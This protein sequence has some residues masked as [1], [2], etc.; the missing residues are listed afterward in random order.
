MK[1]T[2]SILL[3]LTLSAAASVPS[4]GQSNGNV[5]THGEDYWLNGHN[6]VAYFDNIT[7]TPIY[8]SDVHQ[9][10]ISA[11]PADEFTTPAAAVAAFE[12]LLAE[13][14]NLFRFDPS[15]LD[16]IMARPVNLSTGLS[17]A[18]SASQL[19]QGLEV[20]GG[21][22]GAMIQQDGSFISLWALVF[23]D[24]AID[25]MPKLSA[26]EADEFVRRAIADSASGV[27]GFMEFWE[28]ATVDTARLVVVVEVE[29]EKY[30][31]YLAWNIDYT[32]DEL[33]GGFAVVDA[34][35]GRV[36]RVAGGPVT[37]GRDHNSEAGQSGVTELLPSYPNPASSALTIPYRV[38][39]PA[40]V[41][42]SIVDLL[43]RT[44]AIVENGYRLSGD[45]VAMFDV[46]TLSPGLYLVRLEIPGAAGSRQVVVARPN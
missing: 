16:T 23:S 13:H 2:K 9:A 42:L 11:N 18:I 17:W 25:T 37:T 39:E 28:M 1:A 46:S 3:F 14:P 35:S 21:S 36:V 32:S 30:V 6:I 24:I 29:E 45:H 38:S 10:N 7:G 15:L 19:Y 4:V 20:Q 31:Y 5:G 12:A 34:N 26:G 33:G 27:Y 43:G 8:T 41:T 40:S 22:A 44:V